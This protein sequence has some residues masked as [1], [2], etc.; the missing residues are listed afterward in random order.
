MAS[1][2]PNNRDAAA[3]SIISASRMLQRHSGTGEYAGILVSLLA[4]FALANSCRGQNSPYSRGERQ[5]VWLF[6]AAAMISVL[7]AWGRHGFLYALFYRLP[8]FSMI[9]NPIK[10]LQPFQ[11]LWLILA[12]LRFGGFVSLLLAETCKK[13]RLSARTHQIMVVRFGKL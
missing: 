9:R 2:D 5:A 3:D 12:G 4:V 13:S 6:G 7:A 11:I 10:F 1:S 8:Y